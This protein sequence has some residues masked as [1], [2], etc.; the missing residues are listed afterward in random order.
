LKVVF[1]ATPYDAKGLMCNA[2][3]GTDPVIFFESQRLYGLAEEFVEGGVPKECYNVPFGEPAIRKTGTDLTILTI[4][5]TLYRAI[6]AAK[7]MEDKYGLSCEIIDARSMVPF[8]YEKVLESVKKTRKILLA[9][10]ACQ[11]G[12]FLHTMASTINTLAFDEL[13][14]P[15]VVLGARNWITP[16]DEVEESFFPYPADFLDAVHEHI[17]PLKGYTAKRDCSASELLRRDQLG[18]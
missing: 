9:S 14:A 5:A 2:L 16:P 11:R 8:N 1:P 10:D 7:E 3:T 18:L 17:I 15:P 4:G 6:D 13:D 12:S